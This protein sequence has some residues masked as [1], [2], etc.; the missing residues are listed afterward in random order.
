MSSIVGTTATL[1]HLDDDDDDNHNKKKTAAATRG[2]VGS[3]SNNKRET[4]VTRCERARDKKTNI[5]LNERNISGRARAGG[6]R[7]RGGGGNRTEELL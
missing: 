5:Q 4:K 1:F 6:G 3:T 2:W 7:G